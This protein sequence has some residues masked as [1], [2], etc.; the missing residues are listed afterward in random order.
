MSQCERRN[1][2]ATTSCATTKF[3]PQKCPR[4]DDAGTEAVT[5]G[6]CDGEEISSDLSDRQ[7]GR[8]SDTEG[9]MEVK[10]K[11]TPPL[12][13]NSQRKA[14]G[15]CLCFETE[16]PGQNNKAGKNTTHLI[17]SGSNVHS[18]VSPMVEASLSK[19]AVKQDQVTF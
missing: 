14:P 19:D 12:P 5:E 18:Y 2:S 11:I 3:V 1:R 15:D 17:T 8:D 13:T 6:T 16:V 9:R 7:E 4:D 10:R